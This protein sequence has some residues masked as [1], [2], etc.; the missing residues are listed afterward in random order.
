M[1]GFGLAQR[2]DQ[3]TGTWSVPSVEPLLG[4]IDSISGPVEIYTGTTIDWDAVSH[5]AR[6]LL[7]AI[8]AR[9]GVFRT[10]IHSTSFLAYA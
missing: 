5:A 8:I 10:S 2:V 6:P 9:D 3:F 4:A 7:E 1:V